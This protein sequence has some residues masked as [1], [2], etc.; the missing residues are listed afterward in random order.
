METRTSP[1]KAAGTAVGPAPNLER[2]LEWELALARLILARL[3]ERLQDPEV[4][5]QQLKT[6]TPL[7]FRGIKLVSDLVRQMGQPGDD[8]GW[9]AVLDALSEE[10]GVEL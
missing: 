6:W 10:L 4:D 5:D 3:A 1:S 9:D 7:I 8:G 2:S